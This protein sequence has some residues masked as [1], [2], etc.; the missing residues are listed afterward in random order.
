MYPFPSL[1]SPPILTSIQPPPQAGIFFNWVISVRFLIKLPLKIALCNGHPFLLF[2]FP[3]F[4]I[5]VVS[6][7]QKIYMENSKNKCSEILHCPAPFCQGCAQF[8]CAVDP[9]Y[10]SP[11][12]SCLVGYHIKCFCITLLCSSNL[13]FT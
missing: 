7:G 6:Y 4:H 10:T 12:S 3:W 8:F 11:L 9:L 5:P 1:P 13:D 2:C